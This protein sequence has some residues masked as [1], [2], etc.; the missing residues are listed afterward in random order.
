MTKAKVELIDWTGKGTGDPWYS[1]SLMIWTK[2]TRVEMSPGG[3]AEIYAWPKEKKLEELRYMAATI[4]SSWEFC[5]F[6]FLITGVT[7]AFTHQFVRTRT[8]SVAMQSMQINRVDQGIGW[9]YL[10]GPTIGGDAE[11]FYRATMSA[12]A[13]AYSYLADSPGVKVEDARGVLPTNIL[14]NLVVKGNL[15]AWADMLQ[16]RASPRNQ[17]AKP[18]GEGEWTVVHRELR[19]AMIVALPWTELFLNRTMN[20]VASELYA[21]LERVDDKLLR[22]NITKAVDELV[23]EVGGGE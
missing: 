2:R 7:R 22:T 14:N 6:T 13:H 16:K 8:L 21:L 1:A 15:R 10:V 20:V 11:K 12:I 3:L 4:R 18:G 23:T 5:D 17:G 19:R 9:D